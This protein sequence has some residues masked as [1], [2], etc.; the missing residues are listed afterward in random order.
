MRKLILLI[1]LLPALVFAQQPGTFSN[2]YLPSGSVPSVKTNKLYPSGT[3]LYWNNTR[4]DTTG[5]GLTYV[6]GYGILFS[7]TTIKVDTV[8][9]A[10]RFWASQTFQPKGAY[11]TAET[12]PLWLS[13]S[14]GYLKKTTAAST[15]QPIGSYLT[16]SSH[17]A[18][19]DTLQY[20]LP[21]SNKILN[22]G[23]GQ[24]YSSIQAA[25]SYADST[26][27]I[28]VYPGTYYEKITL[29]NGVNIFGYGKNVTIIDTTSGTS[30]K[31]NGTKVICQL[32]NLYFKSTKYVCLWLTNTGSEVVCNNVTFESTANYGAIINGKLTGAKIL[33]TKLTGGNFGLE[34][35]AGGYA[36]N[37]WVSSNSG[38]GI[39]VVLGGTLIRSFGT[40]LVQSGIVNHGLSKDSKSETTHPYSAA[41]DNQGEARFCEGISHGQTG[42][43][44]LGK[45][46]RAYNCI[47]EGDDMGISAN[48]GVGFLNG[49]GTS[50]YDSAIAYNCKGISHSDEGFVIYN[51]S[52]AYN[53]VGV[54]TGGS[55]EGLCAMGGTAVNCSGEAQAPA[56]FH[57]SA[58]GTN[59]LAGITKGATLI[60]CSGFSPKYPSGNGLVLFIS[61]DSC[62][63]DGG[64]YISEQTGSSSQAIR[65]ASD[66]HHV[67]IRGV[68]ATTYYADFSIV[69]DNVIPETMINVNSNKPFYNIRNS[70]D[71]LDTVYGW[72]NWAIGTLYPKRS[73]SG[74]FTPYGYATP[75]WCAENFAP[76]SEMSNYWVKS[77]TAFDK[78][79]APY[80][81]TRIALAGKQAT[82]VSGTT[83]K[84]INGASVL[85]AGD[86]T[87]SGMVYPSAGLP[88]STGSAWSTSLSATAPSFTTSITTPKI[89][90]TQ[91]AITGGAGVN[92]VN[93]TGGTQYG[94]DAGSEVTDININ[95]ARTIQHNS[96]ALTNQRSVIIST[97]TLTATGATTI[98]DADGVVIQGPPTGG[99]NTTLTESCGL[100]VK[101]KALT[102]VT[103]GYG[104]KVAAPSGAG[105]NYSLGINGNVTTDGQIISTLSIGTSPFSVT[106]TTPVTNLSIGGNAAT[107]TKLAATKTINGVA[108][109]GSGDIT[110]PS[111]I[112]PGTSGNVLTSN[113]SVW[114]SAA[115]TGGSSIDSVWRTAIGGA[116][117]SSST[118]SFTGT[119]YDAVRC[120]FCLFQGVSS[121]GAIGRY[122][123]IKSCIYSGGTCTATV[124]STSALAAG[125]KL[126]KIA[127]DQKVTGMSSAY[128]WN[129]TIPGVIVSDASN[130]QGMFYTNVSDTMYFIST[131]AAVLTAASGTGA[132]AV[133]QL[134]DNATAIYGTAPDMTTNATLADQVPATFY[135]VPPGHN[136]TLRWTA[137]AGGTTKASDA[138]VKITWIPSTI[139]RS[140]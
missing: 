49:T 128:R 39:Y 42:F 52:I 111:N 15:Y 26:Y 61:G 140:K 112:A 99:T 85:G 127:Y 30:V 44:N 103:T 34:V 40:S 5:G 6:P 133:Y 38:Y 84:T 63:I 86:L 83:I 46:A 82:L 20:Y 60:N 62:V 21:K 66:V 16:D 35:D 98:S 138:Q 56:A 134:Y 7:G 64:S 120:T 96:G 139:I 129:N 33:A 32:S 45:L 105:T 10:Y 58:F 29:K 74:K 47:G 104:M 106:S 65:L 115:P 75:K 68:T 73:D 71:R 50:T 69:A 25:I 78:G 77:D 4:L 100:S 81:G 31:D 14:S 125:D 27:S 93:V 72:G 28:V 124:V 54:A 122:G 108:F 19:K 36:D 87:V 43:A 17:F 107:A 3:H 8:N 48:S 80:Y 102:N 70:I 114:N 59:S 121:S 22:V 2:I 18:S 116:Y 89:I 126:F 12:D 118:F 137:S 53:C 109:D 136:V 130:Y 67:F 95:L 57:L 101:T 135:K 92:I 23:N 117:A 88:V 55:L 1:A 119:A 97:P 79:L 123:Y 24:E 94:I 9:I 113:G 131:D 11:L 51:N 37:C 91:P 132:S 41:F 13:D 110:V 76:Y 90:S